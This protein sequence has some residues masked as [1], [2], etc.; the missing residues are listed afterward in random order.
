[1]RLV[2]QELGNASVQGNNAGERKDAFLSWC[3]NCA[4]P[5]LGNHF[6][7]T[8]EV[9]GEIGESCHRLVMPPPMADRQL[10]GLMQRESRAW[11]ARLE[12]LEADLAELI[13]FVG[14]PGRVVVLDTSALMEGEF[15][16]EFDWHALDPSLRES[17]VRLVARSLV[18][19]ELD[20]LKRHRDGRQR[21]HSRRVLTT[22]WDLSCVARCAGQGR[23]S[24][25]SSR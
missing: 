12:R 14:R 10:Y 3:D 19:E 22:L 8:D 11:E 16:T 4:S 7:A 18:A 23:R 9:F 17:A 1:V 24:G 20:D 15:F 25:S 13:R 6:P 21:A 5:Q 2:R